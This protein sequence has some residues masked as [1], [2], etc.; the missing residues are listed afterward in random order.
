MRKLLSFLPCLLLVAN[1]QAQIITTVVGNG[2]FGYSGDGGPA[3]NARIWLPGG[4]AMDA[5][6]NLY[7]T[8]YGGYR[9]RKTDVHGIIHLAAGRY[10]TEHG[11]GDGGPATACGFRDPLK[12]AMDKFGNLYIADDYDHAV[13]KVDAATGIITQFAGTYYEGDGADGIPATNAELRYPCGVACDTSGNVYI[14]DANA[15]IRKVTPDGIITTYAG[16]HSVGHSGDGGPATLA[17]IGRAEGMCVTRDGNLYFADMSMHCIRVINAAG[18]ISTI[19]GT[20]GVSGFA[21]DGSAATEA[22][23]NHP[24]GVS[25]DDNRNIYIAEYGN[26]RI[27]KVNARGTIYTVAGTGVLGYYGDNVPATDAQFN[28]PRDVCVDPN[29]DLYIADLGNHRVRKITFSEN[30]VY[31]IN[32]SNPYVNIYPNPSSGIITVSAMATGSDTRIT[33]A[34]VLGKTI[35]TRQVAGD[36]KI[37]EVFDLSAL[38][39]GCYMISVRSSET[40]YSGMV[41]W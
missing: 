30:S 11:G 7:N 8:D 25:V 23:L 31:G 14:A 12:V 22:K 36:T 24:T 28:Y 5:S 39:H 15:R 34:D 17:K 29:G 1:L 18:I 3:T 21:G 27:R 32:N 19:V 33:L 9:V 6:G 13:R 4:I 10:A 40:Q 2:T 37:N 26:H 35:E 16:T 38:P 20:P 41:R